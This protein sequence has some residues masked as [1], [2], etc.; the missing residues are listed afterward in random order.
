VLLHL[1][2]EVVL[3]EPVRKF[4]EEAITNSSTWKGIASKTKGVV[5]VESPLQDY[6]NPDAHLENR[7]VGRS[8]REL[9]LQLYFSF[10]VVWCQ[11][12]LGHLSDS[13]LVAFFRKAKTALRDPKKS[14]MVVKENVCRG[15]EDGG[16]RTVFDYQDSSL[17]RYVVIY[18]DFY[19]KA[20]NNHYSSD[21]A[22]LRLFK[23]AGLELVAD[24]VQTGFPQELYQVKM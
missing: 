4:L 20:L 7:V 15:E 1:V 17:T 2:D 14:L 21:A 13:H 23:E 19:A 24:R 16:A 3:I 10:D 9:E 8:G 6:D 11:W 5:F 18:Y 22:W 12:C